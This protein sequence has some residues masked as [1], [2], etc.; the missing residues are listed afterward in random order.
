MKKLYLLL[1]AILSAVSYANADDWYIKGE[2]F[3]GSDGNWGNCSDY[4]FTQEGDIYYLDLDSWP[5]GDFKIVKGNNTTWYSNGST[6]DL[7]KSTDLDSGSNMTLPSEANNKPVRLILSN[8]SGTPKLT[9]MRNYLYFRG[10]TNDWNASDEYKFTPNYDNTYTL[11][12]DATL[13]GRFLIADSS[14]S[15][16]LKFGSDSKI[17][18]AESTITLS[19]NGNDIYLATDYQLYGFTLTLDFNVSDPDKPTLKVVGNETTSDPECYVLLSNKNTATLKCDHEEGSNIYTTSYEN[20]VEGTNINFKIGNTIY[21]NNS[22]DQYTEVDLSNGSQTYSLSQLDNKYLWLSNCSGKTI[23]FTITRDDSGNYSVTIAKKQDKVTYTLADEN[24]QQI[25]DAEGQPLYTFVADSDNNNILTCSNIAEIPASFTISKYVNDS[26]DLSYGLSDNGKTL[27]ARNKS[28][29][30]KSFSSTESITPFT[31]SKF[32]NATLTLNLG[33]NTLSIDGDTY[34]AL[35]NVGTNDDLSDD[36]IVDLDFDATANTFTYTLTWKAY[37][38]LRLVINGTNYGPVTTGSSQHLTVD[39]G[40]TT[41][42]EQNDNYLCMN[43]PTG[44]NNS[45]HT[46]VLNGELVDGKWNVKAVMDGF[47]SST[48]NTD[49]EEPVAT[50]GWYIANAATKWGPDDKWKF[51]QIK[52]TDDQDTDDQGYTYYQLDRNDTSGYISS[53]ATGYKFKVLKYDASNKTSD[54]Y[55]S[56]TTDNNGKA[57]VALDHY[58]SMTTKGEDAYISTSKW[59]GD[60]NKIRFFLKVKGDDVQLAP[61]RNYIAL[62]GSMIDNWTNDSTVLKHYQLLPQPNGLYVK[63]DL[64]QFKGTFKIGSTD[65]SWSTY[66]YGSSDD[67]NNTNHN[68]TLNEWKTAKNQGKDFV[69]T[70]TYYNVTVTWDAANLKLKVTGEE[71]TNRNVYLF[72]NVGNNWWDDNNDAEHLTLSYS[73]KS[74]S[75]DIYE[76]DYSPSETRYFGIAVVDLENNS[77]KTIYYSTQSISN[78]S[79]SVVNGG[80][81]N[82]KT[83]TTQNPWQLPSGYTYHITV[84]V[85][86]SGNPILNVSVNKFET[87]TLYGHKGS[88]TNTN[89]DLFGPFTLANTNTSTNE[90]VYTL[91]VSTSDQNYVSVKVNSTMYRCTSTSSTVTLKTGKTYSAD[92]FTTNDS[93]Q[94]FFLAPGNYNITLT[95]DAD[96]KIKSLYID[97]S[98]TLPQQ[99][100]I[101]G[102]ILVDGETTAKTCD[103]G[104]HGGCP[105]QGVILCD[106]QDETNWNGGLSE[107]ASGYYICRKVKFYRHINWSSWEDTNHQNHFFYSENVEGAIFGLAG[108]LAPANS[109]NKDEWSWDGDTYTKLGTRYGSNIDND[110]VNATAIDDKP[111]ARSLRYDSSSG[112][113]N[114][115]PLT[116][117]DNTA[118]EWDDDTNDFNIANNFH[119]MTVMSVNAM[120]YSVPLSTANTKTGYDYNEYDVIVDLNKSRIAVSQGAIETTVQ[121]IQDLFGDNLV[122][123]YNMQGVMLRHNVAQ[124]E[125]TQGLPNGIYIVGN[126]KVLV[127]Q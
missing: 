79:L 76:C 93:Y 85:P 119:S 12:S 31:S 5:S 115:L 104:A 34:E 99:I 16:S 54:Y 24:G 117:F 58:Y 32:Y 68:I 91:R 97:G 100:Y 80:T 124:N 113:H 67:N 7:N 37:T 73:G 108:E 20:W 17:E 30:I 86:S 28:V 36:T 6:L 13:S 127:R 15:Y 121:G 101:F 109:T 35:Y 72:L 41:T 57:Y 9:I 59:V 56:T 27:T 18:S 11:Q 26:Y 90:S 61:M 122:N 55:G 77:N 39:S 21:G 23:F 40:T 25:T 75:G 66:N 70:K 2:Y 95:L 52:Y 126:K 69:L 22:N 47:G 42:F 89:N 88:D 51:T 19:K 62:Q 112:S 125:A 74:D 45:T 84:T 4:K 3:S 63:N 82:T 49:T 116:P 14:T 53:T 111:A 71:N 107:M 29:A 46:V 50:S 64:E 81:F 118:V 94:N 114:S 1:L 33:D 60:R 48:D 96:S 110:D 102:D 106:V 105:Y 123:V 65:G 120:C 78:S 92:K 10:V 44:D 103:N 83:G 38:N 43:V 87:I 8:T 98:I